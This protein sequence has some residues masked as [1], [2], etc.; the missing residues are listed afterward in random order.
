EGIS[1]VVFSP[2]GTMIASSSG[3]K[4]AKWWDV[5]SG[6]LLGTFEGH[7]GIVWCLV[8]GADGKSLFSAA[9]DNTLR[10]V[11]LATKKGKILETF[12]VG[13]RS[14]ARHDRTLAV[15]TWGDS[16]VRLWDTDTEKE[17]AQIKI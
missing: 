16:F 14:L 12:P 11:D 1:A 13:I 17:T 2:D 8:F 3:D 4:T 6:K 9:D 15:G 7:T 10:R 5:A